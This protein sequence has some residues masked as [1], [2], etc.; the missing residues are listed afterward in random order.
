MHLCAQYYGKPSE[1]RSVN[2]RKNWRNIST[3]AIVKEYEFGYKKD[4]KA[5][6]ELALQ[7]G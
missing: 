6:R 4:G 5:H 2:M 3:R 1:Q 7:G